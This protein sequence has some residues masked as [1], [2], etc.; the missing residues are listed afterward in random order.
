MA[1]TGGAFAQIFRW[2]QCLPGARKVGNLLTRRCF[3]F[4]TLPVRGLLLMPRKLGG[5]L[6]IHLIRVVVQDWI[7]PSPPAQ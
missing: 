3:N 1:S 6:D 7:P 2:R 5:F 4:R